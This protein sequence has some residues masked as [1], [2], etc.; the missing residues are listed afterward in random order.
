LE[1]RGFIFC[2]EKKHED[3]PSFLAVA[4]SELLIKPALLSEAQLRHNGSLII[5]VFDQQL[6]RL[7][8]RCALYM[9]PNTLR[10]SQER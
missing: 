10:R 5:H 3:A 4:M 7:C 1:G 2:T 8:F 6:R 9:L